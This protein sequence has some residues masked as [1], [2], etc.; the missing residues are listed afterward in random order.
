MSKKTLAIAERLV[1]AM[2]AFF[3]ADKADDKVLKA[4]T[5]HSMACALEAL[6]KACREA[7]KDE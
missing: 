7:N 2:E 1:Q 5:R 3:A 6:A 4:R